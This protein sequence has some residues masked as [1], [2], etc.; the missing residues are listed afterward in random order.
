MIKI[1]TNR[2][3]EIIEITERIENYLEEKDIS[4]GVL[5]LKCPHTTAGI[6]INESY[7]P[8]VASDI[9]DTLERL[10]PSERKYK[11]LEGNAH[12]HIKSSLIGSSEIVFVEKGKLKMGRWQGIFFAEFDGPRKRRLDIKTLEK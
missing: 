10:I 11:H 6:F 8:H 5:I 2:K 4:E 1:K 9:L 12:A 7:D 3:Q